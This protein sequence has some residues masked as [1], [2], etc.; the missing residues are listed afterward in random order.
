[1][2][3]AAARRILYFANSRKI[4][5]TESFVHGSEDEREHSE[6][7]E[8]ATWDS[9]WLEQRTP[10]GQL[11]SSV[12]E[13]PFALLTCSGFSNGKQEDFMPEVLN[14]TFFVLCCRFYL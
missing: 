4:Q 5:P 6:R 7:D 10:S 12:I 1:M 13:P 14:F 8:E 9:R 3:A 2:I 11:I